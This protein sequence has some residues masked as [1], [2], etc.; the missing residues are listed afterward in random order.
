MKYPLPIRLLHWTMALIIAG[1]LWA[2][3]TMVSMDDAVPAKFEHFYPWH[4]SFGMLILMLVLVRLAI[5]AR[6]MLPAL[7]QALAAW[8][9]RTAKA[10]HG[11]LYALMV[12]VPL[13]GY[14]MSSSYT[15]SDGVFFFGVNLPELLPKNDDRFEVFRSIHKVLAFVLLGVVVL[16]ALGAL[17]HRFVDRDRSKDVLSRMV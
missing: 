17:K 6:S 10:A 5:R 7:P 8:E 3:L 12:L 13:A 2:G 16:H 11:L 9:I 4:K 15:Q 1:L 14:S